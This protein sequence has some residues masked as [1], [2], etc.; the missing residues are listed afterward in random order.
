MTKEAHVPE[1]PMKEERCMHSHTV[2]QLL[3]RDNE[4]QETRSQMRSYY[5]LSTAFPVALMIF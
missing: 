1:S 2:L 4:G 3:E 5:V